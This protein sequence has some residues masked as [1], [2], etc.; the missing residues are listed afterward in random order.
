ME[1]YKKIHIGDLIKFRVMNSGIDSARICNYFKCDL[2]KIQETYQSESLDVLELLKWSKLLEY[3]FFRLY[4]QHLILYSPARRDDVIIT[5]QPKSRL[6][7]FKKNI[8]TKELIDFIIEM[9]NSGQKTKKE[10]IDKYNIPKTTLYKWFAK[11]DEKE[12]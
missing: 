9:V 10:I 8:Y 3:D 12:Q 6:P 11:Y 1:N 7:K 2:S 5:R 4:S